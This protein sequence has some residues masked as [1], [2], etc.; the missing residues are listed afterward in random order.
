MSGA[1][2]DTEQAVALVIQWVDAASVSLTN[3]KLTP[4]ER[5]RIGELALSAATWLTDREAKLA[6][7]QRE[8]TAKAL[9]D[10]I[11]DLPLAERIKRISEGS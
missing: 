1:R 3:D 2:T 8:A 4:T 7:A 5:A 6:K 9:R 10:S 11:K